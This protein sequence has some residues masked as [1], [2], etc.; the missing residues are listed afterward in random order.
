MS[1]LSKLWKNRKS[2]LSYA[3]WLFLYSRPFIGKISI[4]LILSIFMTLASVGTALLSKMIIDDATQGDIRKAYIFIAVF[5][6]LMVVSQILTVVT[7]LLSTMLDEKFS[8]GI[9]KQ[10]Y[11]KIINSYWLDVT[12]YHTGDLMTR[13]TSDA[14][15]V[16]QGIVWTIPEI[17][18]LFLE[19]I[20]VF[21]TLFY[22]SPLLAIFALLIAPVAAIASFWL[23]KKLKHLQVKVQE[24]ESNYRSFLQESLAN[25]LIVKSF[26]NEDYYIDKLVELREERFSWVYKR[27]KFSMMSSTVMTMSFQ[28]G[29]LVAL[30]YGA[31]Q[32]SSGA[33]T[34]GTMS[35]FLTMVSRVQA[36]VMQ[37]VQKIPSVVSV[38]ASSGRII[39]LQQIANEKKQETTIVPTNIG[40]SMKGVS[41]G[42][43][44][45]SI[46]EKSDL[47]IKGGEFVAIVGESGIG[48]TTLI[49]LLMSFVAEND[50]EI[51]YYN[52]GGDHV[53]ANAGMREFLSYVP[54]GNT[55]FSGTIREN[56]QMGKI[57]ATEEEMYEALRMASVHD[58]VTQLPDGLD[59]KIGEKGHRLS[60]GQAQRIAIA[61][62][63]IRQASF[64]IL[65]EATSALDEATEL[66]VLQ[67]LQKLQPRP[68][69]LIITHRKSILEYCD[70]EIA[71]EGK[72]LK[73]KK[74]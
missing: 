15:N 52:E 65:D 10:I 5:L 32:I 55:L 42:Y 48:K 63:L 25:L 71:I 13:M 66:A 6:G 37:L 27:T 44:Q 4:K 53:L 30:T 20:L 35:L 40:V 73:E 45:D 3:K 46:L 18:Q 31:V 67:N 21:F 36:P 24:S 34:F 61:R 58:F 1:K 41:F 56:L 74:N 47:D 72:E 7:T 11:E 62:A 12:K 43:S 64:L 54:Q 9:R 60:E 2:Q 26:A 16:A 17:I 19:L 39:E 14:G 57:K 51:K 68:T 8:F 59:T 38:F 69:C 28:I 33:I 23:G 29:F 49:R 70:R 50:G 22:F